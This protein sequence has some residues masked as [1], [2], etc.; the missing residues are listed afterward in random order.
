MA[1]NLHAT[2][3]RYLLP[4]PAGRWLYHPEVVLTREE[5]KKL[6]KIAK[7]PYVCR[8]F[9]FQTQTSGQCRG[10]A[11]NVYFYIS[12]Y[13]D[14]QPCCFMPV[15]FGN[16]REEPLNTLLEK[17][18]GHSMFSESWTKRMCPMID[19]EFRKK[20]I[21]TIPKDGKLPFRIC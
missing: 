1:K 21:D 10:L 20:Y 11:D 13:G 12:P 18:W 5:E 2:G 14:V 16:I 15:T 7:F 19:G 4:T 6:R 3:V 9:Y 17:M 8:D